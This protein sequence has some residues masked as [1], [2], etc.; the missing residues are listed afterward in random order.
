MMINSRRRECADSENL[1]DLQAD[2]C[3][4]EAAGLMNEFPCVVIRDM[5]EYVD[6]QRERCMGT[7][8]L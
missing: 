6:F 1:G 4:S 2:F 5:C 8:I 3:D 7:C